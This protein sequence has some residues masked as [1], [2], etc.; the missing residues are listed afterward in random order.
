MY[1]RNNV[2][3]LCLVF[4]ASSCGTVEMV[5]QEGNIKDYQR[6]IGVLSA[7]LTNKPDNAEALRDLGI[8]Y[9]QVKQYHDAKDYLKRSYDLNKKDGRTLLYYGLTLE[10]L[11]DRPAALG[12]YLNY[13]DL[14]PLSPY[15]SLLE[16]RYRSLTRDIVQAQLQQRVADEQKLGDGEMSEATIAVFPFEYQGQDQKYHAL[17]FGLGELVVTDLAKVSKLKAVERVRIDALLSELKFGQSDKVDRSTAPRLGRLLTAGRLLSG[18]YNISGKKTLRVD[19]SILNTVK[20]KFPDPKSKTDDLDN[21]FKIEKDLVF[22]LLKDIGITLTRAERE[23]IEKFPT[24]NLQAFIMYSMGL[25]KESQRDFGAASVYFGQATE[26]DPSFEQAK[27]KAAANKA[28]S[29]AGT[30]DAALASAYLI[31]PAIGKDGINLVEQRLQ[32]LGN[33]IGSPF[34]PGQ[35]HRESVEEAVR[36]GAAV[37]DLAAP[38]PPPRP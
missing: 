17:G 8:I 21:L 9:F 20:K 28:L 10:S 2:W 3:I 23:D 31:N 14:S 13:T 38:P 24:K 30:P 1:F 18:T 27:S 26:L 32:K 19:A 16:G 22:E 12:A 33:N 35:D 37:R 36:A 15:K 4:F 7:K 6:Q 25:E 29:V 11:E 5:K 34:F